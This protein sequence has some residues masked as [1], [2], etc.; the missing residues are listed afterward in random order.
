MNLLCGLTVG[1]QPSTALFFQAHPLR[2]TTRWGRSAR[3]Q[4]AKRK[5]FLF[6]PFSDHRRRETA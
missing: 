3:H 1:I 5:I 2:L 6:S 4:G